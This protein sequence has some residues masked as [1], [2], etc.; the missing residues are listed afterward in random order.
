[1]HGDCLPWRLTCDRPGKVVRN[2][3][4]DGNPQIFRIVAERL[5]LFYSIGNRAAFDLT[6]QTAM[7]DAIENWDAL[8]EWRAAAA[9]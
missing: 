9:R 1:M 4:S 7:I 6:A 8:P 5:V 2:Q 3:R